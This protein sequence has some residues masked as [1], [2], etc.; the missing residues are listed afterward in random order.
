MVLAVPHPILHIVPPHC[1]CLLAQRTWCTPEVYMQSIKACRRT[2]TA[3]VK[4]HVLTAAV[5]AAA[6]QSATDPE[7]AAVGQITALTPVLVRRPMMMHCCHSDDALLSQ[8]DDAGLL[9]IKLEST[10]ICKPDLICSN[11]NIR[12]IVLSFVP[13]CN[14]MSANGTR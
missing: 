6:T 7:A 10:S 1:A 12:D 3:A 14:D 11:R 9:P 5:A 8:T 13:Y 4:H 2:L